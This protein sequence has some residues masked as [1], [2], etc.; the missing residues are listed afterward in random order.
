MA[1]ECSY[2]KVNQQLILTQMGLIYLRQL[3]YIRAVECFSGASATNAQPNLSLQD[4][5][6][7][8]NG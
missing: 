1:L 3:D 5:S 8:C 2:D 6:T 4:D 7:L